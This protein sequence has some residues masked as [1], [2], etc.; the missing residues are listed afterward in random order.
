[1]YLSDLQ[2]MMKMMMVMAMHWM[3]WMMKAALW[4]K[5]L[6]VRTGHCVDVGMRWSGGGNNQYRAMTHVRRLIKNN[7]ST[8]VTAGVTHVTAARA[9][10]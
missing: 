1:M 8:A 9:L 3:M 6:W 2:M 4:T 10:R 7:I 5:G